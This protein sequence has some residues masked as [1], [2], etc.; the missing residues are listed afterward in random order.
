MPDIIIIK[1]YANSIF[2]EEIFNLKIPSGN[3]SHGIN[4]NV[5]IKKALQNVALFLCGIFKQ[6]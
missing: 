3:N 1:I 5:V 6:L 2:A 4:E